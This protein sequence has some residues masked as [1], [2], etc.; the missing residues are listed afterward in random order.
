M[1]NIHALI[2][3]AGR[4]SRF[5]SALPKQYTTIGNKTILEHSVA[6]LNHECIADL[7]LVIAQDDEIASTLTFDFDKP[8]YITTGGA[9]R[10]LSV[11]AGVEHIMKNGASFDDWVLIHDGARPCLPEQD[12]NNLICV[13]D[14]LTDEVGA[15]LATPV[16]DTLKFVQDGN[17]KHTINRTNLYQAQT[18]QVFKAG[19]LLAMLDDVCDKGLMITDEASGFEQLGQ[20]VKIVIGS[21]QNIK[22]T[23]P[24]DVV[25][26]QALLGLPFQ[27]T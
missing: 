9:E 25:M 5:G 24:D 15:I 13:L 1:A 8:I 2:V 26:I 3:G 20:M 17:I 16:A 27:I 11:K 12:L 7:T 22:L 10:F 21:C 4:G 18:P 6:C 23:Y 19:A 14:G